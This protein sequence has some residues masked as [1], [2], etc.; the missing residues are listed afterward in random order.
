MVLRPCEPDEQDTAQDVRDAL[1]AS[2]S[3]EPLDAHWTEIL[4]KDQTD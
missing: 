3:V 2:V 1:Q 4:T